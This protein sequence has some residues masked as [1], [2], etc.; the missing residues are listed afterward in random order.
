MPF[1]NIVFI[2]CVLCVCW[3]IFRRLSS[4]PLLVRLIIISL[5]GVLFFRPLIGDAFFLY[6]K[7]IFE[8]IILISSF[9]LLISKCLRTETKIVFSSADTLFVIFIAMLLISL[10][11]SV[12]LLSAINQLI[13]FLSIY[14]LYWS[15]KNLPDEQ[16]IKDLLLRAVIVCGFLLIIYAVYQYTVGFSQMRDFLK[17]NPQYLINSKEFTKRINQ[18]LIFATFIYPPAFGDYLSM[19]FLTLFGLSF[20]EREEA[21]QTKAGPQLRLICLLICLSIIPILILTKSKGAWV[22]LLSGVAFFSIINRSNSKSLLK[23]VFVPVLF[24]A[25]FVLTGVFSKTVLPSLRNFIISYEI[26]L[27][28]WKTALMM[29]KEH[30]FLGFGPGTFGIVYPVFKT[31]LAEETIMA[32]NSFL[33]LWAESGILSFS[34]FVLFI[35][36]ILSIA[37]KNKTGFRPLELGAL[38]A[39]FSFL[40]QNLFDFGI[41]DAQRSTVAFGLLGLYSLFKAKESKCI[42]I[43]GKKAKITIVTLSAI[44][45]IGIMTYSVNIYLAR[46]FD[47]K[48]AAA[49]KAGRFDKAVEFSKQAVR[50]NPLSAEYFYHRA[51][52]FEQIYRQNNLNKNIRDNAA[53]K[54]ISNYSK[55]IGLNPLAAYY[56]LR[57]A[58]LLF[59]SKQGD[60]RQNTLLHL[61]KAVELYPVNPIYHEH[62]AEFYAIIGN[63]SSAEYEVNLAKELRKYFKKGTRD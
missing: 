3:F 60:Y 29:I 14:L 30:P 52:I 11:R 6:P 25:C 33:Q 1:L 16:I 27:E 55:A 26:R 41:F 17:D 28:Y 47:V 24:M 35:Y 58:K 54:A 34:C 10:S 31:K 32:H 9:L 42:R 2:L 57:L 45:L 59:I 5:A 23:P 13:Y 43:T 50:L 20:M 4:F 56:H 51:Y 36:R 8:N 12:N 48:T 15:I 37:F 40:L 19:L 44:L 39:F 7:I 38:A 18:N 21:Q 46:K 53:L 22:S 62:L 49:L 63:Q 61:K